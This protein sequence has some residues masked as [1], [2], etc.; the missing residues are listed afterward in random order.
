MKNLEITQSNALKAYKEADENGK[1]LLVNMFGK[2]VFSQKITDRIKTFKD[3]CDEIGEDP[4]E[5]LPYKAPK[6]K[7]QFAMNDIAMLDVIAAALKGDFEADWSDNN[8][9]KWRPWFEYKAS[10]SGFGFS[11]SGCADSCATTFVGSRLCMPT[12]ELSNYFGK[13]FIEI[14]NRVLTNKY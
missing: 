10:L 6:N 14:H 8:E 11:R 2:E 5:V 7:R 1:S 9:Y 4:N 12:E 13:Q 3:A